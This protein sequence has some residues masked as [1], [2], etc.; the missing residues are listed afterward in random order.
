MPRPR[1]LM[2]NRL[3]IYQEPIQASAAARVPPMFG[4][5][6]DCGE[7]A[8]GVL[9]VDIEIVEDV[10]SLSEALSEDDKDGLEEFLR[11]HEAAKHV[12]QP[13]L[14]YGGK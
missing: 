14:I 1:S 3:F 4:F 2:Q 6:C 12:V 11:E 9:P 5:R 13:T 8:Y 10:T 7:S